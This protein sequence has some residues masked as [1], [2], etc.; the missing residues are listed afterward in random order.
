VISLSHKSWSIACPPHPGAGRSTSS[1]CKKGSTIKSLD[2]KIAFVTGSSKGIGAG[3]A[4]YVNGKAGAVQGDFSREED[5]VRVY[6]GLKRP[7]Q[8]SRKRRRM[9]AA[10]SSAGSGRAM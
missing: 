7:A 2:N 3:V 1:S 10:M 8:D 5:I 9:Q 6:A 4:R